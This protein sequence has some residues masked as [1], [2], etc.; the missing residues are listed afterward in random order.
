MY[1]FIIV[2]SGLFGAVF[3]QRVKAKG[4][5][6]IVLER[7]GHIGGNIYTEEIEGINVHKYGAHIFHTSDGEV[8]KYINEFADFNNYI[9][10][11]IANYNGEIYNMP[12][13]M[14]TFN[15]IWGVITPEQ[16]AAK[17]NEGRNEI[18]GEPRNLEE[19]AISLVGRDIY[20]KLVKGYTEKQWGRKCSELPA[21]II[22]RLPVRMT[23]CNN[24]FNDTWQGIPIG[25]YTN[26]IERLLDG[27]EVKLNTDFLKNKEEYKGMAKAVIYTG[28]IDEYYEYC[29]GPLEYRSLRFETEI[30]DTPNYQGVA[31]MNYTDEKTPYTRVIEHKHFEFGEQSK[32]VISR[33]YSL[34]WNVGTEPYYPINDDKNQKR[35]EQY[36]S[37]AE[38]DNIYFCGRLGEYR[39]YDMDDTVKSALDKSRGLIK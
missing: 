32:T 36:K 16:A 5:R 23:Y 1:D 3:A 27:V 29:F 33:E 9:N 20:E 25:G 26:I 10:T 31:V 30:I 39:Y 14:N 38:K 2:G 15:K 35:Y 28:A 37:L 18:K 17:I 8:W 24:Y 4:K 7:R 12:F 22:R 21:S 11:P 34:E 13:N 6:C 19:Q